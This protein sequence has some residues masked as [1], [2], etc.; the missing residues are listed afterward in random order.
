[1]NSCNAFRKFQ[2]YLVNR[3]PVGLAYKYFSGHSISPHRSSSTNLLE[4]SPLRILF[5]HCESKSCLQT[6][7][8]SLFLNSIPTT[9]IQPTIHH[10]TPSCSETLLLSALWILTAVSAPTKPTQT[11]DPYPSAV[12]DTSGYSSYDSNAVLPALNNFCDPSVIGTNK[13]QDL[14]FFKGPEIDYPGFTASAT[15]VGGNN[16]G[17]TFVN[18]DCVALMDSV[19]TSCATGGS[20]LWNCVWWNITIVTD[21]PTFSPIPGPPLNPLEGGGSLIDSFSPEAHGQRS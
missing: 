4:C 7:R 10:A 21:L 14:S 9:P 1:M 12:C 13:L 17:T 11:P 20:V 6:I 8:T 5:S 3:S 18:H 15:W 19:A 16:C 2:A